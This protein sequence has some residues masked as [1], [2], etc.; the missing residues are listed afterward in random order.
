M[1]T[2]EAGGSHSVVELGNDR[3]LSI[4]ENFNV[5]CFCIKNCLYFTN[6]IHSHPCACDA[7]KGLNSYCT[8]ILWTGHNKSSVVAR[9]LLVLGTGE[10]GSWPGGTEQISAGEEFSVESPLVI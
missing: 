3:I 9:E 10:L 5:M 1:V 8:D 4:M 6:I 7:L 2:S